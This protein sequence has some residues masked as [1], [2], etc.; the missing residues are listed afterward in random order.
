MW[1]KKCIQISSGFHSSRHE[2]SLR[3]PRSYPPSPTHHLPFLPFAFHWEIYLAQKVTEQIRSTSTYPALGKRS[4][5]GFPAWL[6]WSLALCK[7]SCMCWAKN[8]GS[9]IRP[10][11][12]PEPCNKHSSC[13][14]TKSGK[15]IQMCGSFHLPNL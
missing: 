12:N 6:P 5:E 15:P 10:Y 13:T 7:Q 4:S 8:L 3:G 9:E 1:V 2:S 11:S 14:L